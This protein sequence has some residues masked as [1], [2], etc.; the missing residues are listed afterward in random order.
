[1]GR[2]NWPV[3]ESPKDWE[4]KGCK[5]GGKTGGMSCVDTSVGES[6]V[7]CETDIDEVEGAVP[8]S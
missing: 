5:G 8:S 1:M 6:V 3:P 4:G 2:R 7:F